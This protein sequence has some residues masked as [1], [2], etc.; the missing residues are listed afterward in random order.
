[1]N[2]ETIK[3]FIL[4]V[5]VGISFLLSYILW[6]YQPNYDLF[7]D[8]SYINEVDVGGDER[9][10]AD[11]I[12]PEKMIFHFPNQIKGFVLPSEQN[13]LYKLIASWDL[14]EYSI[15]DAGGKPENERFIEIVYPNLIS[16]S[17]LPHLF[18]FQQEVP[19]PDWSFDRLYIIFDEETQTL[20]MKIISYDE[21]KQIEATFEKTAAYQDL[22]KYNEDHP[23]LENY[24][25]AYFDRR[26]IYLPESAR[27]LQKKTLVAGSINSELFINALFSNPLLVK[28]NVRDGYFTDG[29]RGMRLYYDGRYL[30][31]INPI[32]TNFEKMTTID[33]IE[34]SIEHINEHKGWLN[35]YYIELVNASLGKIQYRLQHDGYP[36]YDMNSFALIEQEWRE[37]ELYQYRRPLLFAGNMLNIQDVTLPSGDE[38]INFLQRSSSFELEKI[39]NI[40]IGYML[41]YS[42][43]EHS[44]TLS[45]SWFIHYEGSWLPLNIETINVG[46]NSDAM[47]T[48]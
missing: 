29:Q 8:A 20:N 11:L 18:T 45:P 24:I 1:M 27:T 17:L 25:V 32:E 28:S 10:K 38:I 4:A 7:Y 30:E 48:D 5:L 47:G 42:L 31:Y 34:K 3:S 22:E 26:P 40:Q 15:S 33:L 21:R 12:K 35:E 43:E 13:E 2:R 9:S 41:N 39:K 37:F 36:V 6:S 44:L 16:A 23:L 46:G 19:L 14:D